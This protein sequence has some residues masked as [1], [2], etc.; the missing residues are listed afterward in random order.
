MLLYFRNTFFGLLFVAL[1]GFAYA[2]PADTTHYGFDSEKT[3]NQRQ[4][5][6]AAEKAN[7]ITNRAHGFIRDEL[8]RPIIGATVLLLLP[9]SV[10]G[11]AITDSAGEYFFTNLLPNAYDVILQIPNVK[12]VAMYNIWFP[13]DIFDAQND[14]TMNLSTG[15]VLPPADLRKRETDDQ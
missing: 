8:R 12:N 14:F 5:Q 2:Q 10:V 9:D 15:I 1:C 13:T 7:A 3:L 11:R 4:V 6:E